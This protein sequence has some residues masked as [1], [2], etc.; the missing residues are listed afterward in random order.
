M[1]ELKPIERDAIPRAL[2]KA[3]RYR[4]LNEPREA[5]SI[6]RDVLAID[7][8]NQQAL[9]CLAL[10]MTDLF[11][12]SGVRPDEARSVVARLSGEFD[13]AYYGGV[14]DERWGKTLLTQGYERDAVFDCLW[15]AMEQYQ[16]AEAAAP[17]G[18][19]DAVL[20]WNACV[21]IIERHGLAPTAT[22]CPLDIESFDDE[23][24]LR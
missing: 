3:E 13:R 16:K 12:V 23:V 6:C 9:I 1:F 5:D 20:R 18:N 2:E 17:Q 11:P 8:A 7:P 24:P 21:R 10:A 14:I 15:R 19:D 4:L 22:S